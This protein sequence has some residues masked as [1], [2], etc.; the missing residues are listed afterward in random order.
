MQ[1]D[2][3]MHKKIEAVVT[4][5]YTKNSVWFYFCFFREIQ[6][7]S[8][9][10]LL[11]T[12]SF[13]VFY[14]SDFDGFQHYWMDL[15][16]TLSVTEA[17]THCLL[18]SYNSSSRCALFLNYLTFLLWI[19]YNIDVIDVVSEFSFWYLGLEYLGLK[20]SSH[21][22]VCRFCMWLKLY[23]NHP[24]KTKQARMWTN[25]SIFPINSCEIGKV[26]SQTVWQFVHVT[27]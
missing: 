2:D 24:G 4:L 18:P 15:F 16:A 1:V 8:T 14:N 19:L 10:N 23:M 7:E 6:N 13:V 12:H 21:R 5:Q 9:E 26:I 17:I 20:Y 25:S 3:L 27:M 11:P 22:N